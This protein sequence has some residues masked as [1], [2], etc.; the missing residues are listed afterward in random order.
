LA[1]AHLPGRAQIKGT[2]TVHKHIFIAA[3][4]AFALTA[5]AGAVTVKNVSAGEVTIGIDWGNKEKVEKIPAGKEV[6]FECKDGCGISGPWE[7]SWRAKGNDVITTDGQSLI[8][9]VD[10]PSGKK[11]SME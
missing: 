6:T 11:H 3:A 8:S 9:V 7:F 5:P 4:A 10:K 1:A 2:G